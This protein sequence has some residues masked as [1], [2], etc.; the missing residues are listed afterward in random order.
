MNTDS[1]LDEQIDNKSG[2]Y[3]EYEIAKLT[4]VLIKQNKQ[5]IKLLE[6]LVKQDM[7]GAVEDILA[8]KEAS[9]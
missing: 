7:S 6:K 5:I 2:I 4:I 1:P 9:K 8:M 3:F